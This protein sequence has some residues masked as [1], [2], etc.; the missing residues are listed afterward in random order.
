MSRIGIQPVIVPTAVKT[1]LRGQT[2]KVEGPMGKVEQE[3]HSDMEIEI[4]ESEGKILVRRPSEEKK[5]KALHGLTRTL[6]HNMVEGVTKGYKKSLEINGVG[7]NAKMQGR[8]LVLAIGFCHPVILK[9]PQGVDLEIPHPTNIVVKGCDK[10]QVG[11]F[12]ANIR[13]VRP[14]EPY[15]G[16]GIR[17]TGEIIRLKAGKKFGSAD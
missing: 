1:F 7:Y 5:H 11:Q 10:Q 3:F 4:A 16:K 12:A 17:Y 9:I 2:L 6:I 14:P 15:K 13:R 8:E